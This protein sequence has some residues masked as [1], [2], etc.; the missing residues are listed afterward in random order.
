MKPNIIHLFSD[1]HRWDWLGSRGVPFVNT[2]NLDRLA[3]GGV[4]FDNAYCNAPLCGP[5]RMSM[6]TGRH[7]YRNDVFVNEHPLA[8]DVPTFAHALAAEGYETVLGGRMHFVWHDQM[9]GFKQRLTGDITGC[10]WQAPNTDYGTHAGSASNLNKA[11]D[12]QNLGPGHSPVIDYDERV[13][14]DAVDFIASYGDDRPLCMVVGWYS[15]HHPFICSQE[16]YDWVEAHMPEDCEPLPPNEAVS[17]KSKLHGISPEQ[18]RRAR[19]NYAGQINALD[20]YVGRVLDA[21]AALPGDTIV[22]Y[23]SDHGEMAGDQ[24]Y[25]GKCCFHP[26]SINVPMIWANL[27]AA[28][29]PDTPRIAAGKVVQ[30]LVSLLDIAPTLVEISG[31]QPLPIND[32]GSLLG[33]LTAPDIEQP[34]RSIFAELE[35]WK[36]PPCRMIVKGRHKYVYFHESEVEYLFDMVDDADEMKNL[37]HKREVCDELRKLILKDW[38]PDAIH[39]RQL[40]R[41][42]DMLYLTNWAQQGGAGK[43]GLW[44]QGSVRGER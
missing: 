27:N 24:G 33:L 2:P 9:H 5:S 7:P 19:I 26:G 21:A 1:Q 30:S 43:L 11:L 42:D 20:R 31:A 13:T 44:E 34:D 12:P 14:Q 8:S 28:S 3:A 40:S 4:R 38:D 16:D 29:A 17:N 25:W 22:I 41:M 36:N 15:P 10:Y 35:M 39:A 32:G 23:S 18:V 6:L 37:S